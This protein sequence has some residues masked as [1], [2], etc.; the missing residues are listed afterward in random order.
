MWRSMEMDYGKVLK[1]AW[2]TA[3]TYR[4]L[5]IFG[6][7]LALLT[8]S[9]QAAA[10]LDRDDDAWFTGWW[11]DPESERWASYGIT[12]TQQPGETVWEALRRTV[13]EKGQEANR[14]LGELFEEE[15]GIGIKANVWASSPG[16]RWSSS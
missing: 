6:I 1:R 9:W 3:W 16:S 8:F 2:R 11:M 13:R 5:W 12:V 7:V 15:L 10:L 4:A 14:A